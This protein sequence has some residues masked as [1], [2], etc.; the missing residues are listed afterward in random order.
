MESVVRRRAPGKRV[1]VV[2]VTRKGG[3]DGRTLKKGARCPIHATSFTLHQKGGEKKRPNIEGKG[4][5]KL[6]P[7][8][9]TSQEGG[10]A[11][12]TP[13]PDRRDRILPR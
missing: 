8:V 3:G 12:P 9:D 2:F 10:D 5:R 6:T 1:T 11:P 13:P 4:K 7:V